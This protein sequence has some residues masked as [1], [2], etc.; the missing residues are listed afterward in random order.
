VPSAWQKRRF[1]E[2]LHQGGV[3]GYPTEAVFGLGCDPLNVDAISL[4][5]DLKGRASDKGFI[6]IASNFSQFQP[7]IK[8]VDDS[9]I[10][11]I[12][13][14][15]EEPTTWILPAHDDVPEW[16]TAENHT[17]AIRLVQHGLAKEL[18]HLAG[19]AL[20]ST[21]ANVSGKAPCKTAHQARLKFAAKGVFTI[22]GSVGSSSKPSR[23]IDLLTNK[24]LR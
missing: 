22:N 15:N 23:I 3:V 18:C 20:T 6:L 13:A 17:I 12:L 21:S 1:V 4:L 8:D 10:A 24:Q 19:M 2:H 5:Q 16:L 9:I 7:Y 11:K 14:R